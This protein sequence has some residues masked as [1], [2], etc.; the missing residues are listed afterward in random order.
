[1]EKYR[2][3]IVETTCE[4]VRMP[5]VCEEGGTF[6][7]GKDIDKC[8]DK[9]LEIFADMGFRTFKAEDGAYGYAEIGE[10]EEM[11]GILGHLDVVSARME[12]GW[13]H[14]PFEPVV[15]DGFICGRGAQDDKGPIVAAAYALKAVLD[16]G[17]R[18]NKRVRFIFGLD[19]ETLWR[20]I[21]KYIERE[22]AP[23]MSF[24]PDSEFPLTYAEKGLLQVLFKSKEASAVSFK[25]GHSF[26]AVS[27]AAE[28]K[29]EE[30]L[31]NAM[32]EL[33]YAYHV[34]GDRLVAEGVS[35]HAKDPWKGVSANLH[36]I[37]AMKKAG[38]EDKAISFISDVFN[39]KFRFEGFTSEDLSDFSGPVS[40]CFSRMTGD[41]N[42]VVLSVDLRLPVTLEK[43]KVMDLMAAKA[44]EYGFELEQFD[45][46]R[47]IYVPK[48]SELIQGL[49]KAY[50]DV[51]GDTENEPVISA[52]ATY[53]RGFDNCVAFG[54]IF[55]GEEMTEHE[56]N[57]R[58]SIDGLV[59][60]AEVFKK[61]FINLATE[62]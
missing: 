7:F 47:S 4:L 50:Q 5:S 11:L 56:P 30:K 55:P 40:V 21:A 10:G 52:G 32:K 29:Y 35:V 8:L 45:W 28:C 48:D 22:E 58:A 34:E 1:M 15:E 61:V 23:T 13:K 25:G 39:D 57:E 53:A 9:A 26:N 14:N 19:E 59:R 20:S 42:G 51:T 49:M 6:L 24:S 46:L 62:K 43:Q 54:A 3:K 36:L 12:D 41:E 44:A 60:A 16:E 38:Y 17:Y 27:S 37:E 31:E 33:G 18:L 2:S